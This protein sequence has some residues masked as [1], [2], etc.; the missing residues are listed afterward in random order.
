[1]IYA[2]QNDKNKIDRWKRI[3]N[4]RVKKSVGFSLTLMPRLGI[5]TP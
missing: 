1:M 4:L 5:G 3:F 2:N